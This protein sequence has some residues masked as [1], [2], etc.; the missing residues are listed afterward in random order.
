MAGRTA[1]PK[2][3][4]KA[5]DATNGSGAIPEV[6][7]DGFTKFLP[8]FVGF[9]F[10]PRL[11]GYGIAF[12]IYT[13]GK[14]TLYN[15]NIGK[16]GEDGGYLFIA[17]VLMGFMGGWLNNY[18]MMYKNMVMRHNSGNLRAN[19]MFFKEAGKADAPM[20]V[21]ETEGP[22]GAY[23]RANRSLTHF[24]ETSLPVVPCILLAGYIF[25]FPTMVLTAVFA[26]GRI[27]HQIGYASPKGYGA[28][29]PG[30]VLAMVSSVTLEMLCLVVAMKSLTPGASGKTEL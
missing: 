19:M 23:N 9:M 8:V 6:D 1:S 29:A 11:I 25:P 2:P 30:F 18:P 10:V 21:L 12:A 5:E 27:L 28:H 22:V 13:Y 26:I 3:T 24:T 14:T 17:A 16:L 7:P 4:G 20:V 15:K